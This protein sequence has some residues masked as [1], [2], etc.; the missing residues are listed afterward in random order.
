MMSRKRPEEHTAVIILNFKQPDLTLACLSSLAEMKG[1]PPD[2][3]VVDNHSGDDSLFRIQE[4]LDALVEAKPKTYRLRSQDA[5]PPS[6]QRPD[7]A[8]ERATICLISS[9]QN[10]GFGGG[11]NLGLRAAL[12][13]PAIQLFWILNN[14]TEITPGALEALKSV[15]REDESLGILG[16]CLCYQNHPE[17]IQGVGGLYRPWLGNIQHVLGGQR[18]QKVLGGADR[19]PIDYAVGAAVCIRRDVLIE[20][21]LFPEDYFLYFEDMDWAFSVRNKAPHWRIDYCLESV[22]L[23]REGASTGANESEGKRTTLLADY[24]YQRNRLRFARRWYPGRYPLVHLTQLLVFMNRVKRRQ[25]S[26]AGIA[27]G[28]FLGWVPN[29][30]KPKPP[31]D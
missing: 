24:Y 31:R 28:L 10:R 18:Y 7:S 23:H 8:G 1:P 25:W 4:S 19:P 26:L 15:F 20:V 12:L 5:D 6:I 29:R 11:V 2:I 21:G 17:M 16:S 3:Y 9:D 30:L 14:D 27:L 13:D 22:V